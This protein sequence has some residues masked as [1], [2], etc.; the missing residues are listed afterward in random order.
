MPNFFSIIPPYWTSR[1]SLYRQIGRGEG[2]GRR[3]LVWGVCLRN[4]A[5]LLRRVSSGRELQRTVR[6]AMPLP[7]PALST[8]PPCEGSS[9]GAGSQNRCGAG[10]VG[11]VWVSVSVQVR[12]GVSHRFSLFVLF[13]RFV[14]NLHFPGARR[15]CTSPLARFGASAYSGLYIKACACLSFRLYM[16]FLQAR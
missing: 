13:V 10:W 8:M 11:G 12:F 6:P 15:I 3:S 2:H 4:P 7:P 5:L 16:T 14:V 9:M 1:H